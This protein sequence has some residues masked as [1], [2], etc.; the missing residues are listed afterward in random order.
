VE[1]W[2][3]RGADEVTAGFRGLPA[4]PTTQLD[5]G[6]QGK[7]MAD[8]ISGSLITPAKAVKWR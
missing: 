7:V 5:Q 1:C 2:G 6:A 3:Y 4:P 8:V